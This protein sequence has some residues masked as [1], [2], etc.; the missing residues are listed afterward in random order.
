MITGLII[1]EPTEPDYPA[2]FA[3]GDE[4]DVSGTLATT[5]SAGGTEI[6]RHS[7]V[8]CRITKAWWDY[9]TGW[10]YRGTPL[11]PKDV[12][13]IRQ[14][15]TSEYGPAWYRKNRPEDLEGLRRSIEAERAFDPSNVGFS[16]H[17]IARPGPRP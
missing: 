11:D 8:R 14:Q 2:P 5:N 13:E 15:A 6:I 4:V 1:D 12:S 7:G 10:R 17:D 3:V 9:E 16:E